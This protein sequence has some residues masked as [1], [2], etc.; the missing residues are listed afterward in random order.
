MNRG[1]T[2]SLIILGIVIA[3]VCSDTLLVRKALKESE[4]SLLGLDPETVCTHEE[5]EK[6]CGIYN[7]ARL[8]FSV[9]IAEGYL[10]EYE[11]ALAALT[12]SVRTKEKDAYV[13][14]RAEAIA[15]L[16]QIKRSA[17]VSFG[18]IF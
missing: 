14:A 16:A 15:A 17:L 3:F 12:A 2:L 5:V 4:D 10:N 9:S 7:R 8:L 6:V 13:P 11:E 1:L 18:Q